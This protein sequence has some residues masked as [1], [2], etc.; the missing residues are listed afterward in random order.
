MALQPSKQLILARNPPGN[1]DLFIDHQRRCR[2]DGIG[3]DFV[4][5][6]HMLEGRFHPKVGYCIAGQL[7]QT[8]A[9]AQPLPSMLMSMMFS[10]P[11]IPDLGYLWYKITSVVP[12]ND[13]FW[14]RLATYSNLL[15]RSAGEIYAG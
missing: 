11:Q 9:L 7:F 4:H 12:A 8:I 13:S 10:L 2:H 1:Y 5:L 14:T 6:L 15:R 3:H